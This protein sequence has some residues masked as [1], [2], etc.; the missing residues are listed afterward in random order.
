M[1]RQSPVRDKVGGTTRGADWAH[2]VRGCLTWG[3]PV[4]LLVLSP[5]RYFVI[6]WPTVLTFM[7]VAC[8]LNA[9]R[10]GRVHCYFTGPFFLLLA[11]VGLLYG[12]GVLPLGTRG[13]STLSMAVVIGSPILLCAPEWILGRYRSSPNSADPSP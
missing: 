10:C 9:R 13:W 11:G 7:G 6:V 8:L 4:A 1:L 2:G 5:E 3:M 12:L